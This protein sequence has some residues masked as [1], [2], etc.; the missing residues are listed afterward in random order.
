MAKVLIGG[1]ADVNQADRDGC[2][3]LY[4]AAKGNR[5]EVARLLLQREQRKLS[6]KIFAIC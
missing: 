2:T 6:F 4:I 5:V 1:G 3:P